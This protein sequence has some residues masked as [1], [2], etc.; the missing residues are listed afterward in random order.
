MPPDE[1][2]E[3]LAEAAEILG[4]PSGLP[5]LRE[6]AAMYAAE[7]ARER[8]ADTWKRLNRR[9]ARGLAAARTL[10]QEFGALAPV[11]AFCGAADRAPA[12]SLALAGA[13]EAEA[14]ARD[15]RDRLE[16]AAGLFANGG[17]RNL[18]RLAGPSARWRLAVGIARTLDRT[19]P[20]TVSSTPGG[21]LHLALVRVHQ[22]ALGGD[23]EAGLAHVAFGVGSRFRRVRML[24]RARDGL[25]EGDP[26]REALDAEVE[27]LARE[28][29]EGP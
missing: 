7:V 18:A 26:A 4:D 25:P 27:E 20:G 21:P 28:I 17:R 10:R 24:L 23:E 16:P 3:L 13:A 5:V 6:V 15:I 1:V 12:L 11:L 8:T 29:S 19:R 22:A 2:D 14:L 9:L